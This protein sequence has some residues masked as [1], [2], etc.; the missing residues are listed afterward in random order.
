MYN[1]KKKLH[2][3]CLYDKALGLVD[4]SNISKLGQFR[5]KRTQRSSVNIDSPRRREVCWALQAA[6][7]KES[8]TLEWQATPGG[9]GGGGGGGGDRTLHKR[10]LEL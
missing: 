4:S 9:W 1:S 3:L 2:L 5:H 10:G 6:H 8:E 7:N